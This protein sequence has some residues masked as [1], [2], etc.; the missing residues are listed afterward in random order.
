MGYLIKAVLG[1]GL[2]L[3]SVVL[4]NVKLVELL[5]TGT[6][7]SGGPYVSA[8]PC[9]EGTGTDVMLLTGSIFM[10]LIGC[11]IFAFR[12]NPPWGGGR[13]RSVGLFGLGTLAWGLFFASTGAVSLYT[14]LTN[15]TIGDDGELGAMIV[16]ITFLLMGVPALLLAL[17]GLAKNLGR[18]RDE[19]PPSTS[20]A[21]APAGGVLGRFRAGMENAQAAQALGSRLPWGSGGGTGGIPKSRGGDT[22]GRLERLQKLRESG[23]INDQEF[24]R[25]KARILA[26]Q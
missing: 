24:E 21:M 13:R 4:F 14:S 22:L 16:G 3:G 12:G 17:W 11:G 19:T 2:F 10:G 15:D 9:P 23:A 5:E 18:G 20:D 1:L 7:A 6:C 25:E 26:E 8:R